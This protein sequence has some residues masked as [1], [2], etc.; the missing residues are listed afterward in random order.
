MTN[1]NITDSDWLSIPNHDPAYIHQEGFLVNTKKANDA[2]YVNAT[3][4][5]VWSL[6]NAEMTLDEIASDLTRVLRKPGPDAR[7]CDV[8]DKPAG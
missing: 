3:A 4:F 8:G 2:I 6:C 5:M 7:R 1:I